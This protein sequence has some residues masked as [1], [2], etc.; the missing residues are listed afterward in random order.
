MAKKQQYRKP[1]EISDEELF[2]NEEEQAE[3]EQLERDK[4]NKKESQV[5]NIPPY[6]EKKEDFDNHRDWMVYKYNLDSS[7]NIGVCTKTLLV[8]NVDYS[9]LLNREDKRTLP[10]YLSDLGFEYGN[11]ILYFDKL[12]NDD[13]MIISELGISLCEY[14]RKF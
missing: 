14:L 5:F 3:K 11:F 6:D 10:Q 8:R 2:E 7:L 13:S 12:N 9:K 4:N 1:I